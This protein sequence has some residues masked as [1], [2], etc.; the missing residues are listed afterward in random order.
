[1]GYYIG[2]SD[3]RYHGFVYD[4]DDPENWVT[5]D[6]IGSVKTILLGIEGDNLVGFYN[7]SASTDH[8]GFHYDGTS[9]TVLDAPEAQL[10]W[11][12]DMDGGDYIGAWSPGHHSGPRHG[13][14][15]DGT[16]WD[17]YDMPGVLQTIFLG[18]ADGILFGA[19]QIPEPTTLSLLGLGGVLLIRR[20]RHTPT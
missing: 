18:R 8:H 3:G 9:Y 17:T 19:Y 13:F 4:R 12:Q 6:P 16:N 20:R 11:L 14:V 2:L 10:T 5:I 7:D 15:S 1:V